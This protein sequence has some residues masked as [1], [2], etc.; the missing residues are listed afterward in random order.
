[1]QAVLT[2]RLFGSSTA[3]FLLL[4]PLFGFLTRALLPAGDAVALEAES[5]FELEVEMEMA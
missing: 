1:M 4:F 3:S 5:V 2:H